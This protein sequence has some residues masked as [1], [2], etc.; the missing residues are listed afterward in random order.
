[1]DDIMMQAKEILNDNPL[2][3]YC[4]GRL[5]GLLGKHLTNKQRGD[6][7]KTTL[8]LEA[9]KQETFDLQLV[10]T[11]AKSNFSPARKYL[12]EKNIS[13]TEESCTICN[14]LFNTLHLIIDKVIEKA[15]EYQ[16]STY[17]VGT[18]IPSYILAKEDELREYYKLSYGESLKGEVNRILGKLIQ[19]LFGTTVDFKNPDL[20]FQVN[21][22]TFEVELFSRSVY[23]Y[24]RYK[25]FKRGISQSIWGRRRNTYQKIEHSVEEFITKPL[26]PLFKAKDAVLHAAGREDID[27]LMLGTGRPFVVE[28]KHPKIRYV[29]LDIVL[30]KINSFGTGFISVTDL[31]YSSMKMV[32]HLKM[33][34]EKTHKVYQA[35]VQLKE[36]V[37]KEKI[38]ALK[39]LLEGVIVSQRTPTR[40]VH[41][42]ADKVRHKKIYKVNIELVDERTFKL[43]IETQGGLYIKELIN[44]D[45]NR[46]HPNISELLGVPA[47]CIELD[48]LD[49]KMEDVPNGEKK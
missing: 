15:Q 4:L 9:T 47:E 37:E 8:F 35:L 48:V 22:N 43:I 42:R 29:P 24:G 20:I 45:S 21:L 34:S 14:N 36:P 16:F 23:I 26:I 33:M 44:G 32:R 27:A 17:L 46:T 19:H 25:K 11:L 49:V 7:I 13:I 38:Y 39:N 31:H 5:F 10:K 12:T 18:K 40:V 2:C 1:M 41:R 28:I 6:A 30:E 3:S